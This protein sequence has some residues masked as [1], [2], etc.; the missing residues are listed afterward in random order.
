M[1][2][3]INIMSWVVFLGL[4]FHMADARKPESKYLVVKKVDH[5]VKWIGI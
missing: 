1:R 5:P 3:K 4:L 2:T